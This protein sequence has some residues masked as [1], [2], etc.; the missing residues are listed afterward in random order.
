MLCF[1]PHNVNP[2]PE[3]DEIQRAKKLLEDGLISDAEF[4]DMKSRILATA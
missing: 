4:Q 2:N 3:R 1:T